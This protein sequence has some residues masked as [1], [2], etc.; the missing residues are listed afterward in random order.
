MIAAAVA[1][2][3]L[4]GVAGIM[5][6]EKAERAWQAQALVLP[7]GQSLWFR[8][9]EAEKF[10]RLREALGPLSPAPRV[11]VFLAGG[12]IH[13]FFG[14]RRVGRHW[15]FLPEFVRPWERGPVAQALLR[16]DLILVADLGQAADAPVAP[17]VL[18]LWLPLPPPMADKLLPHLK[19][20]RH[21]DGVGDL[22]QVQP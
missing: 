22:L 10:G 21:I 19:N 1:P 2:A 18:S 3:L 4:A 6:A 5:G 20:P 11:A 12:G 8:S 9:G 13:H 14:T 16:H 15:W 17:G 7:N